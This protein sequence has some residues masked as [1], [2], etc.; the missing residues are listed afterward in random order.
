MSYAWAFHG[1]SL[2]QIH[3][4]V[5][6]YVRK[7]EGRHVRGLKR[8]EYKEAKTKTRGKIIKWYEE[9]EIKMC[10]KIRK[11]HRVMKNL[12]YFFSG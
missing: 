4:L 5:D 11:N 9:Q 12:E 7:R 6:T 2:G 1:T 10:K 8:K 3:K